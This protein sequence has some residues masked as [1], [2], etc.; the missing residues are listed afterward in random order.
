MNYQ[1]YLDSPQ[2][3]SGSNPRQAPP[4]PSQSM[5]HANGMNGAVGLPAGMTGLPTPAGHQSDL[6]TIMNMIA[7]LGRLT[8][9]NQGLTEH[10]TSSVGRVRARA[11][12]QNLK[13]DEVINLVS[14]EL[15]ETAKNLDAENSELRRKLERA[16]Y[17]RDENMKLLKQ[18]AAAIG[19]MLQQLHEYKLKQVQDVC[20]WHRSYRNQLEWERSENLRLRLDIDDRIEHARRGL[21]MIRKFTR[22]WNDDEEKRELKIALLAKR[23]ECRFYKRMALKYLPDDDPEFSDD[24]DLIDHVEKQRI[25]AAEEEKKRQA[26]QEAKKDEDDEG[27]PTVQ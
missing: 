14:D 12:E 13:N 7:E 3:G 27:L 23:Q 10:V 26:E 11:Q 1:T 25:A 22:E 19:K 15:N 5:N 4:S 24:D 17:D 16:E 20:A 6:N 2:V 21:E 9:H 18:Y 8:A